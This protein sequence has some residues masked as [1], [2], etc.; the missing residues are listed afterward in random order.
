MASSKAES[1]ATYVVVPVQRPLGDHEEL[2]RLRKNLGLM[3][4]RSETGIQF[5]NTQ[6]SEDSVVRFKRAL[7]TA[8]LKDRM[9]MI[10]HR[11][12]TWPLLVAR[13]YQKM[14]D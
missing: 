11:L 9:E 13:T 1:K 6:P 12:T 4:K 8:N 3:P 7:E 14:Q 10:S 5:R 2:V